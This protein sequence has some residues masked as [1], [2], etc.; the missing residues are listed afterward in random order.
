LFT[1]REFLDMQKKER[2]R[3][4]EKLDRLYSRKTTAPS[5]ANQFVDERAQSNTPD[6]FAPAFSESE[7][8]S[9]KL[10]SFLNRK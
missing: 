5:V 8:D 3:Y 9:M 6:E 7:L 1:Y 4:E 10:P 2:E